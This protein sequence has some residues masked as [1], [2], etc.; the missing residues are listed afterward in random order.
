MN[1]ESYLKIGSWVARG[2]TADI[3]FALGVNTIFLADIALGYC[4]GASA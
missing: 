2:W 3:V 1:K 4:L